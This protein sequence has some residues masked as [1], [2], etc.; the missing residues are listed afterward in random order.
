MLTEGQKGDAKECS[1]PFKGISLALDPNLI[2][3]VPSGATTVPESENELDKQEEVEVANAPSQSLINN[4]YEMFEKMPLSRL[5]P[6]ILRNRG[7]NFKFADL[8][9]D[10]LL[11]EIS[12]E[13]NEQTIEKDADG[14]YKM[15]SESIDELK[16]RE[17][18]LQPLRVDENSLT[19]ESESVSQDQFQQLKKNVIQSINM[20]LN[21]SSLSLE[22]VSLLLSS[23]RPAAATASMSPYLK[24]TVPAASLNAEKIPLKRSTRSEVISSRITHKGWK[25]RSLEESRLL[26]KE[27]YHSLE[28]SIEKEH[29]YWSKICQYISNKDVVFK[30]KDR[31]TGERS[32]GIKYGYED[33]GSTYKQDRGIAILRHDSKMNKLELVPFEKSQ[34]AVHINKRNN[35][36]FLRVRIFT[37]IEEE[38]DYILTGESCLDSVLATSEDSTQEVDIRH[39]ISKLKFFIFD[40]ELMYQ[41]KRE[42]ETLISYGVSIENENKI[43]AEFPSEKIEIEMLQLD[44][45]I[46]MNHQQDAPKTNDKKANLILTML[47]LLLVIMYK[48]QMRQRLL[49]PPSSKRTHSKSSKTRSSSKDASD[50]SI[51]LLR[52]IMGK[53][54]HQSYLDL[55]KKLTKDFILD[56]VKDSKL[57]VI[58][59]NERSNSDISNTDSDIHITK[60]NKEIGMF[61]E[62]LRMPRSEIS[63]DLNEK[64]KIKLVLESSNFCNAV[65][66]V[67]YV[68]GTAKALFDTKF[69]DFKE[70]EEFL[71]FIINE[72]VV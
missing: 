9:E 27:T 41:L 33:S 37:K 40:Q 60:L 45:D 4:P 72:Y 71:H 44:D 61:D 23:V 17:E 25:L 10:A 20:A 13:N 28:R 8:T 70:L 67:T 63:V 56:A 32:L 6:I 26:L 12:G 36:K 15:G 51:L 64:G 39:Q 19:D 16:G 65:I 31:D 59:G 35:E 34:S 18:S 14:D 57:T 1:S 49:S 5:I 54:R 69:S 46:I 55:L 52:P 29:D 53:I 30:M 66:K 22:F 3:L 43:V 2:N 50:T 7:P 42:S 68:N 11:K 24:K 62:I 58:S 38:D 48:K 47:R 21:E